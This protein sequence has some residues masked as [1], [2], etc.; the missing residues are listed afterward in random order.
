MGAESSAQQDAPSVEEAASA[1]ASPTAGE[2]GAE[3]K[4]LQEEGGGGGVLDNKP[5]QKNGQISSLT[6]LNG[7]SE[8]NTL[9]EVGQ[10]DGVSVAQKEDAPETME[11]ITDEQAPQVNGEKVEKESPNA[12][13][14]TPIEEKAAEEKPNET[15][16][17]GFKKMFR[18]VGFKFTLKKDKSEEKDSVKL[19]NV[20][21]KDSDEVNGIDEP[22]KVEAAEADEKE[23]N[24]EVPTTEA[25]VTKDTDNAE[26]PDGPAET[27]E[28]TDEAVKEEEALKEGDA[29][30]AQEATVSPFRKLFSTGLF[31][32]LRKKSSIKK[33]K[34][35]EDKEVAGE[36]DAVKSEETT[37]DDKEEK[38]E[39]EQ[40][41]NK[42]TPTTPEEEI[43]KEEATSTTE[44]AKPEPE[45]T[46]ESPSVCSDETKPEEE[47][48]ST[49][50]TSDSEL[51]TSQEK[52]KPHGS[53]LKKLFAGAGLKKL[54]TKKQ[55]SK[56][57]TEAKVTESGD[58]GTEKL[59][60]SSESTESAAKADSGP[61]TPEES[62]EY[63]IET[64]AAQAESTKESEGEV[65][66]DGEKK[67][68]GII[69]WSS[70]KKLVTPKK[71]VK[72]PSESDD[73]ATSDKAAKS[74]TL[75]S[76]ESAPLADK[77]VEEEVK[78]DKLSEEELKLENTEKLVSNTEEPKRKMD[79][80]V[81][82]EALM[83]MGGP[84]KRTR[85]TSDSDD[86]ETKI[87]EEGA[88]PAPVDEDKEDKTETAGENP[89]N[90]ESEDEA[91]SSPEPLSSPPE[92]E[93][94]WD[95]LKRMVMPKSKVK[96]EERVEQSTEQVEPESDAP[97]E[98][99]SFSL[100]KLF[101]G[102]RKKKVEKQASTE[103]EDDT[104]AV[105]PLSEFDTQ[106]EE[107]QEQPAEEATTVCQVSSKER[108]PSWIPA[109]VEHADQLS[110]I[111]EE[112]ATPKSVDT[113]IADD[114]TED[115]PTLPSKAT[116]RRL[117]TAE[118]AKIPPSETAH[119][120]QGPT[121]EN[122]EEVISGI[123][124]EIS[125]IAPERTVIS[126]DVPI[127]VASEKTEF[128]PT[129]EHADAKTNTLL[130][131]HGHDEAV[132]ICTGLGTKEI[133]KVAL[134]K[135]ALPIME[136]VTVVSDA[137]GTDIS[138]EEASLK[139]EE[140]VVTHDAL[141]NAQVQQ[142]NN[143]EIEPVESPQSEFPNN[144]TASESCEPEPLNV[145][146][147][148]SLVKPQV[149]E[150]TISTDDALISTVTPVVGI[151]VCTQN[152]E[153]T[154]LSVE[155][156]NETIDMVQQIKS[157]VVAASEEVCV[158]KESIVLISPPSANQEET[159][160]LTE[161]TSKIEAQSMVIAQT[162]I[163][164]AMDKVAEQ[165]ST[166][167]ASTPTPV[168]AVAT[169]EKEIEIQMETLI[170]DMPVPI[171][172][173][174]KA[175]KPIFVATECE[176]IPIEVA[177]TLD[178]SV[179]MKP[180]VGLKKAEEVSAET[181]MEEVAEKRQSNDN[182][183][184]VKE[185]EE[186]EEKER[187]LPKQVVLHSAQVV[188]EV[189]IN[190]EAVEEF[191]TKGPVDAQG[192]NQRVTEEAETTTTAKCAEVMAQVIEV[193]EEAVKEIEPVSTEIT[194]VS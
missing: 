88:A 153:V 120:P 107:V 32:N 111:T 175:R 9:A 66:S 177:E 47:K 58:Q 61:S 150:T 21:D 155:T 81:S 191:N 159:V 30:P 148:T 114:D 116:G 90:V 180:E 92:R 157:E 187:H 163:Q 143:A 132:A 129:I 60:S 182:L 98:E 71:R 20:R 158:I 33:T 70:F 91:A 122:A 193:I 40:E 152:G 19:L 141:F 59:Q 89:E 165:P 29:S 57:D 133:A 139:T 73:E 63:A 79:T 183:N 162:V 102:L 36:E 140:A 10:P 174:K 54:S 53:P 130:E 109:S 62:G 127:E 86:E 117:S 25:E 99:S 176:A 15:S 2:L 44:E 77:S 1:S 6:S 166:P 46:A 189:S 115:Q 171:T 38:G 3:V 131:P 93:S 69:A 149:I 185:E 186:P 145:G 138:L 34:E 49:E 178:T 136:C 142:V 64:E 151:P 17:V 156:N 169:M 68:E 106:P 147:I 161:D 12:N 51:Q 167:K 55:K 172:C 134:E 82:W 83:C 72:R 123:E 112:A 5:L 37:A 194:P 22:A 26:T 113:D 108:A 181:V 85:K 154:E 31:S 87:D 135:P 42:E 35:E 146:I 119:D 43:P 39:K 18:F 170:T 104:P 160:P 97:N 118:V 76:S 125:E 164:D 168:Q 100:R 95:T 16:E 184:V 179:D 96:V 50:V 27:A 128:E 48:A 74:A 137:L 190:E 78:E 173:E 121:S 65:A 7:H 41:T 110:D 192:D 8:D 24:I 126:E 28:M 14:I 188:E 67:K 52:V 23:G 11:T 103:C 144:Q 13:D 84:K 4:V 105:V 75:S 94:T 101:P 124:A 56:K 80:S 45:V